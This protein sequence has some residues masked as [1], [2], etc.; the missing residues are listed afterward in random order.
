M[1]SRIT[2]T[3]QMTG[4]RLTVGDFRRLFDGAS[5]DTVPD[6]RVDNGDRF[7]ASSTS[8]TVAVAEDSRSSSQDTSEPFGNREATR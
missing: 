6:I 4:S 2:T 8:V 1:T 7:G 3:R 5:D